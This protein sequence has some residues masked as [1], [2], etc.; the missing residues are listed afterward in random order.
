MMVAVPTRG[1]CK[2][3]GGQR[4]P[5]GRAWH[6]ASSAELRNTIVSSGLFVVSAW[7]GQA[8]NRFSLPEVHRIA[9]AP[10]GS[11]PRPRKS[12]KAS[13]GWAVHVVRGDDMGGAKGGARGG[14]R[15]EFDE[16]VF[17]ANAE[18]NFRMCD[19]LFSNV[20][21]LALDQAIFAL[22]S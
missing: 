4:L 21:L 3:L 12:Y 10:P 20:H 1:A 16:S 14:R 8:Q 9:Y 13:W 2:R 6:L 22:R 18:A 11:R 19:I 15:H 5:G 17:A 7:G